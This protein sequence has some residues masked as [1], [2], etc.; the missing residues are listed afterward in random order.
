M[1]RLVKPAVPLAY[2]RHFDVENHVGRCLALD[3]SQ[4]LHTPPRWPC[5]P[6]RCRRAGC[7]SIPGAKSTL[8]GIAFSK[9]IFLGLLPFTGMSPFSVKSPSWA[10]VPSGARLPSLA[11]SKLPSL[12]NSPSW[13]PHRPWRT[14]SPP[15]NFSPLP[16]CCRHQQHMLVL[17]LVTLALLP[18]LHPRCRQHRN[19]IFDPVAMAL[20]PFCDG[21]APPL[22]RW[23]CPLMMLL[24]MH[25]STLHASLSC[26]SCPSHLRHRARRHCHWG[27]VIA[28]YIGR[29][30]HATCLAASDSPVCSGTALSSCVAAS[31]YPV[32]S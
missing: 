7:W 10:K 29:R 25:G 6:T 22:S 5:G 26:L 20:L 8:R 27:I 1:H 9:T 18:P 12:A 15:Q 13:Q 30:G 24:A 19:G 23:V 2:P 14:H 4:R 16:L 17:S 11:N 28:I 31:T 32:P 3:V 21:V